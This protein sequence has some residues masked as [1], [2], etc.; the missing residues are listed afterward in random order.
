M[1]PILLTSLWE[2]IFDDRACNLKYC[3]KEVH[4]AYFMAM[5]VK[6]NYYFLFKK[7]QKRENGMDMGVVGEGCPS[8]PTREGEVF[9]FAFS[10]YK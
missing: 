9:V 1:N 3:L 10:D 2:Q 5:F 7:E 6:G 4:W 8:A